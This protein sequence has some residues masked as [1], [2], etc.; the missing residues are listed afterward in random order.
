MLGIVLKTNQRVCPNCGEQPEPSDIYCPYCGSSLSEAS[1]A[2]SWG[3]SSS[4]DIETADEDGFVCAK[5][6]AMNPSGTNYCRNCGESLADAQSVSST[7]ARTTSSSTQGST[8]SSSTRTY[9]YGSGGS[10]SSDEDRAWYQPPQRS[11]SAWHP[12]EWFFWSGWGLYILIRFIFQI[13]WWVL[14]FWGKSRRR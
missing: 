1:G 4:F 10:V 3:S 9:S 7:R 14:I 12:V 13:L 6:G 11:R 5:C 2:S 8:S